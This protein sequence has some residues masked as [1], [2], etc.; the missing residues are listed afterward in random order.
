MQDLWRAPQ[1]VEPFFTSDHLRYQSGKKRFLFEAFVGKLRLFLNSH[2]IGWAS[3][4]PFSFELLRLH[5]S[6]LQIPTAWVLNFLSIHV[7]LSCSTSLM[8]WAIFRA[9]C[10]RKT[11]RLTCPTT[12]IGS[13]KKSTSFCAT[14][15][16]RIDSPTHSTPSI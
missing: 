11:R 3:W 2:A 15:P 1:A 12:R 9:L 8:N 6:K 13:R 7:I 4:I 5:Y 16:A 14:R 10:T